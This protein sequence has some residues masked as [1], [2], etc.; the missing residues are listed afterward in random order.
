MGTCTIHFVFK[1]N[2]CKE[3]DLRQ[4]HVTYCRIWAKWSLNWWNWKNNDRL[5]ESKKD[6]FVVIWV[7]NK[8]V[9]IFHERARV[10]YLGRARWYGLRPYSCTILG[11]NEWFITSQTISFMM[12]F[13]VQYEWSCSLN[14]I[15]FLLHPERIF[16]GNMEME[17]RETST[18]FENHRK[19]LLQHCE[20]SELRLHINTYI[21][22]NLI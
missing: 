21:I 11:W 3:N 18:V 4:R 9:G 13:S 19:S 15:S 5:T 16:C 12:T 17:K 6:D 7:K 20:R 10:C 8:C 22:R 14:C 2:T 1:R